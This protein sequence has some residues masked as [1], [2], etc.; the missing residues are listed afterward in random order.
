[1]SWWTSYAGPS[2]P[3]GDFYAEVMSRASQRVNKAER[4]PK[5]QD[6]VTALKLCACGKRYQPN[7][8]GPEKG[9]CSRAC[10]QRAWK[11]RRRTAA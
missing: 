2:A 4:A 10:Y 11:A 7:M 5:R 3:R 1:M 9:F 6:P 8:H